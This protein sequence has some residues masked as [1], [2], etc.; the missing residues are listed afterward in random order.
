MSKKKNDAVAT[1]VSE[2]DKKKPPV[3]KKRK[4]NRWWLG[5]VVMG[6]CTCS[7]LGAVGYS[8]TPEY[9]ATAG[10]NTAV[11]MV[12][13]TESAYA[14][15]TR[16]AMPTNTA[17]ATATITETALPTA[18]ATITETPLPTATAKA[19]ATD[20]VVFETAQKTAYAK[21]NANLRSCPDTKC[22]VVATLSD[23]V[24]VVIDASV[25]GEEVTEG[26]DIWYR[27]YINGLPAYVYHEVLRWTI[28][29]AVTS[30]PSVSNPVEAQS[31]PA[32]VVAPSGFGCNGVNDLNCSDFCKAGYSAQEHLNMCGDE[33]ELDKNGDGVACESGC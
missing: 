15:Q 28:P 27:T 1:V 14:T 30:V 17:T 8:N 18:T 19:F 32:Q 12:R 13:L 29:S 3:E 16:E 23:G 7:Y 25:G 24:P 2:P 31:V 6:L 4:K 33:D 5:L 21:G 26:V 22:E 11:A 20:V 9:K 10:A